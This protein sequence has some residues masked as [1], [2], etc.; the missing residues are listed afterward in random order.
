VALTDALTAAMRTFS[1]DRRQLHRT[2]CVTLLAWVLAVSLGAVNA[3]LL[4]TPTEN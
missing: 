3:C 1:F 4:L 2:A